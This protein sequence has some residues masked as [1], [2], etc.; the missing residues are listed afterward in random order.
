MSTCYAVGQSWSY[1]FGRDHRR[2]H[3]VKPLCNKKHC[4][5][6]VPSAT[7]SQCMYIIHS[8][9]QCS[10]TN[11][12]ALQ[13]TWPLWLQKAN[14]L[15]HVPKWIGVAK[16][17]VPSIH[18]SSILLNT[19][20]WERHFAT[21]LNMVGPLPSALHWICHFG[22]SLVNWGWVVQNSVITILSL[23]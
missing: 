17:R 1:P 23:S 4:G 22:E 14:N 10:N 3:H 9:T 12:I 16:W 2:D 15:M 13:F 11:C 18:G 21:P 20:N 6:D 19:G 8:P 7:N 5:P